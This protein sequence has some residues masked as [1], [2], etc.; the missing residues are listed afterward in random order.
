MPAPKVAGKIQRKSPYHTD[1]DISIRLVNTAS[2]A[3]VSTMHAAG[4]SSLVNVSMDQCWLSYDVHTLR[5]GRRVKEPR[6]FISAPETL[7][8]MVA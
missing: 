7:S 6:N 8:P 1:S 2:V 5:P 3:T 4:T